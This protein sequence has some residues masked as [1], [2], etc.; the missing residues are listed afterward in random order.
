MKIATAFVEIRVDSRQAR[1]EAIKDAQA[2]GK[3]MSSE[4][5]KWLSVA[6]V[7]AG[8][9]KIKNAASDLEQAVGG[10]E[11]VFRQAAGTIDEFAK[12]SVRAVGLSEASFRTLS[13]QVGGLLVNMGLTQEA[14]ADASILISKIGADASAA[15]GGTAKEAV[16]AYGAAIRGE[17]NPAERFGVALRASAVAA[18]AVE[19]G[20]ADSKAAV[21]DHARAQATLALI[22]E[23]AATFQGQWNRELDTTASKEQMAKEAAVDHAATIGQGLLPIYNRLIDVVTTLGEGFAK[24]PAGAQTAI[25]AILGIAA[26]SGPIMS[27]VRSLGAMTTAFTAM[28][29]AMAAHPILALSGV[30]G[31][32]VV[33]MGV[34]GK[35]TDDVKASVDDLAEAMRSAQDPLQGMVDVVARLANDDDALLAWLDATGLSFL[36]V[37]EAA[38]AGENAMGTLIIAGNM[39]AAQAGNQVAFNDALQQSL[40]DL[41]PTAAAAQQ[42][43]EAMSRAAGEVADATDD[44]ADAVDGAVTALGRASAEERRYAKFLLDRAANA[45]ASADATEADRAALESLRNALRAGADAVFALHDAEDALV[46]QV[47]ESTRIL[48]DNGTGLREARQAMDS[49][50]E[51]ADRLAAAQVEVARQAAAA[52]D[53]TLSDTE[54]HALHNQGLLD[55]VGTLEGPLRDALINHIATLNGIPDERRAELTLALSDDSLSPEEAERLGIDIVTGVAAGIDQ[56]ASLVGQ[57]LVSATRGA[58]RAAREAMQ[59]ASPS[60][61]GSVAFAPARLHNVAELL[62]DAVDLA[63]LD[64]HLA[65]IVDREAEQLAGARP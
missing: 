57:R 19:M 12:N 64:E 47:A 55:Q 41:V 36:Q 13:T 6:A 23:Q 60:I 39:Q 32:V 5:A 62:G 18:K 42:K 33:A 56:G 50:A 65:E 9:A 26:V 1:D 7:T 20:L 44:S 59:I 46:D 48:A 3:G 22:T 51:T 52:T 2:I 16:E 37:A 30:L 4:L 21:D 49:V 24:L 40:L 28:R 29:A 11:T 45:R 35:A 58:V 34:F 10:T 25:V 38:L 8:F 15:F 27:V 61:E 43:Y 63:N 31:A 53:A 54:A 14:A 17:Y